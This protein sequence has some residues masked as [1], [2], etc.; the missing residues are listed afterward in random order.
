MSQTNRL[1]GLL[2]SIVVYHGIPRRQKRLRRLYT[3]FVRPGDLVFDVGAHVGNRVRA[4]KALGCHVIAIE[5]QPDCVR[6]LN[7][8]FR[9]TDNVR[10]VESAV[11]N[12]TGKKSLSISELNPTMS[13]L[14]QK[15]KEA[16]RQEQDFSTVQWNRTLEVSTT[17]LDALIV[18]YGI[19][20]FVKIDVEGAEPQVLEGLST[21][22]QVVSFEYI[23]NALE[24]VIDSVDRLN[25]L[26][27]YEF[28]WSP[29]ET[30]RLAN[31]RWL[32]QDELLR[33]LKTTT[34][35]NG[36]GDVYARLEKRNTIT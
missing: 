4:L 18:K 17:S 5:P 33:T 32:G 30:Y 3:R 10:V 21:P 8:M 6:L 22:L 15:W 19:P 34:A 1:L 11:D 13:T 28:N 9:D 31:E 26:G 35:K 14:D 29:G 36:S 16:R 2:R 25:A 20:V 23:P 12:F 24:H 7:V 27:N